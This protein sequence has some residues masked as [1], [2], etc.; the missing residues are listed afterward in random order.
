[1]R[2]RHRHHFHSAH[3]ILLGRMRSKRSSSRNRQAV[4]C[5]P[6]KFQ[7]ARSG[8]D[9]VAFRQLN[10]FD[11]GIFT[12]YS[13]ARSWNLHDFQGRCY[14]GVPLVEDYPTEQYSSKIRIGAFHT[15]PKGVCSTES[16]AI[17]IS[18]LSSLLST[19]CGFIGK[20]WGPVQLR[21]RR[22]NECRI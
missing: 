17:E 19:F 10:L 21:M 22:A 15:L 16:E 3:L 4:E 5:L 20:F 7:A 6:I 11:S 2:N 12:L 8:I 9:Y 14:L 1:M 13:S 18:Y